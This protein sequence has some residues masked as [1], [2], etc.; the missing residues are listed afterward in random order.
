MTVQTQTAGADRA[1]LG[2]QLNDELARLC[3][4]AASRDPNRKLAWVNS[5]CLLFLLIGILGGK[6]VP[7]TLPAV[8]PLEQVIPAMIE[9]APQPPQTVTAASQNEQHNEKEEPGA[10]HVVVVTPE[11]PAINFSVPTIG[12]L[13][14]PNAIAAAPPLKPLEPPIAVRRQPLLPAS[15][16]TT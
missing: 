10:A 16:A 3:L 8:P 5:I 12:T 15:L 11:S 14:V 6:P 13:V 1:P 2:Y 9:P 4:P 7:S